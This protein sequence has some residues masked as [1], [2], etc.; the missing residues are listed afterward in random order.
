MNAMRCRYSEEASKVVLSYL[1]RTGQSLRFHKGRYL[2]VKGAP[3]VDII[4]HAFRD[5]AIHLAT[6]GCIRICGIT[7]P[8]QWDT[9]RIRRRIEDYLRKSAS[10]GEIIRI[11]VCLGIRMS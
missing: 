3:K 10:K 5:G 2:L 8:H 1:L 11:A 9:N 6:D 7:I 4:E